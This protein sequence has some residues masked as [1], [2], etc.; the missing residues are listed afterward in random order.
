MTKVLTTENTTLR[1][2]AVK[3][4][5]GQEIDT[6][7]RHSGRTPVARFVDRRDIADPPAPAWYV[8]GTAD[9]Y[10]HVDAAGI[11]PRKLPAAP[12]FH[13]DQMDAAKAVG[14]LCHEAGHAAISDGMALVQRR[15]PHHGHLLTL[16]EE[17]RV[18]NHALRRLPRARRHLR[19]SFSI[20]LKSATHLDITNTALVAHAWALV[21]GRTLAGI[22]TTTETDPLDTAARTLLGDD[23]V[24]ELTDLLQE[25]VT[26]RLPADGDR[27]VAICDEWVALVGTTEADE[28]CAAMSPD[29]RGAKGSGS[30]KV[31]SGGSPAPEAEDDEPEKGSGAGAAGGDK[32]PGAA[33]T[34]GGTSGGEMGDDGTPG[35][36]G[37]PGVAAVDHGDPEEGEPEP[38]TEEGQELAEGMV[39]ELAEEMGKQWSDPDPTG[40]RANSVEWA[41]RVFGNHRSYK[42]LTDVEPTAQNRQDVAKVAGVLANLSLPAVAKMA[43]PMVIPPGRMRSREAVRASAERAQGQMV[44]A[45]PW[46]GVVR[47]HSAARP[48][49]VGIATDTSGSMGWAQDA[50]A[51]FAYVYANAGHRIG[52]RTAAVTFGSHVY[53]IARPGQVMT[54]VVLKPARDGEEQCDYALAALDGVLHLTAPSPAARILIV[55]SDGF[56]VRDNESAK[57]TE[58]LNR[59]DAV[60]THVLWITDHTPQP[61]F[62]L[63]GVHRRLGNVTVVPIK[64]AHEGHYS[65]MDFERLNA[66]VMEAIRRHIR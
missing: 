9:I 16:L 58:W 29:G 27:M 53:R 31:L 13:S 35:A 1:A 28:S 60:G 18:E 47:R 41:D 64:E 57:V 8:P 17:I 59:M 55:V 43:K 34:S 14:L 46:K 45:R 20:V 66:A 26:L 22:A 56:L 36:I 24:D 38:I 2:R 19:A 63:T 48:L 40:L 12:F 50:V 65:D 21:R 62:W 3:L 39:K 61:G 5:D 15:A 54:K 51:D 7:T 44:T 42:A 30:G 4:N 25:A 6:I 32:S 37:S 49:V 52:A 23:T 10:I 33:G 11:D